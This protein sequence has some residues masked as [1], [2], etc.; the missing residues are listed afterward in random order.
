[1]LWHLPDEL[2]AVAYELFAADSGTPV[3][4][5]SATQR[6]P[7]KLLTGS[8]KFPTLDASREFGNCML[9]AVRDES[10]PSRYWGAF[11][12]ESRYTI[13][14]PTSK[15]PAIVPSH[16][17]VPDNWPAS[18]GCPCLYFSHRNNS[19]HK[20]WGTYAYC[21]EESLAAAM[22]VAVRE[23]HFFG[24]RA[25]PLEI[26]SNREALV[27][28]QRDLAK[29]LE[30]AAELS[31]RENLADFPASIDGLRRDG[32]SSVTLH[33]LV[34]SEHG[35]SISDLVFD[36]QGSRLVHRGASSFTIDEAKIGE[37]YF[38]TPGGA[39]RAYLESMRNQVQ[40]CAEAIAQSESR[41]AELKLA[42]ESVRRSLAG[43][44]IPSPPDWAYTGQST[45]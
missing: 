35:L 13:A 2:R 30:Y 6:L 43:L 41:L 23:H 42:I 20:G 25:Y 40:S 18:G 27:A 24:T 32:C 21:G 10:L 9:E 36:I 37:R 8:L 15:K 17:L 16:F 26:S 3:N 28:A 33:E 39:L 14:R 29:A 34:A 4:L 12:L 5:A 1:M 19:W 22:A 31:T 44:P 38:L 11:S 7:R 45:Q